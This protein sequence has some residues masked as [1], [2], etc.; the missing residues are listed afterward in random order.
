MKGDK[1]CLYGFWACIG[2]TSV[3]KDVDAGRAWMN[4]LAQWMDHEWASVSR[5]P[6]ETQRAK[7][8]V[9]TVPSKLPADFP[10]DLCL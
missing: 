10:Q 6:S 4:S 7:G 1:V 9:F 5:F 8:L 3:S 2:P